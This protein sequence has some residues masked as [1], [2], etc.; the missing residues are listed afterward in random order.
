MNL[1]RASNRISILWRRLQNT[2]A[3]VRSLTLI[4]VY[5]AI[6]VALEEVADYL[7]SPW[8][9]E[10]WNPAAGWHVALIFGFGLRY[11]PVL[12][13]APFLENLQQGNSLVYGTVSGTCTAV[14]YGAASAI[15]LYKLDFDPR[16]TRSRDVVKFAGVFAFA[17]LIFAISEIG[18]L[19]ALGEIESNQ[20]FAKTMHEWAGEAT[21]I[22]MFTPLLLVLWRKF[23]RMDKYLTL[24]AAP[25]EIN[26]SL[27][28]LEDTRNWLGLIFATIL[29]TW[30]ASG[31]IRSQGLDYT[32]FS[33]VPLVFTCAWKGFESTTAIILLIN[34]TTVIFVG[35][36]AVNTNSLALQFG[37]MT[38][39]YTG[40]LLGAFVS[41]RNRES[42]KSKDL[43]EQLRYDA[44]HDSLTGLYNRAWFLNRLD[45]VTDKANNNEDYLFALLFLD[46]DRFKNVNDQLGHIIGDLLLVEIGQKLQECLSESASVARLGG[47]EF[48]ILLEELSNMSQVSQIA[49][50]ICRELNQTYTVDNYEIFISISIGI[51]VNHGDRQESADLVRNADIALYEA[52]ARG[53]SQ[54]IIFDD[55][56]RER[57]IA[58]AQLEQDLRQ[59]IDELL[60]F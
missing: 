14:F 35:K 60:R 21:G 53:K 11:I 43:E 51:A 16:L 24:Q 22:A 8:K 5:V 45:R 46:L 32:Y 25:P 37:L 13:I 58:Q 44:T 39:T 36:N 41:G 28:N 59:A 34:V 49:E 1:D 26:F 7:S 40:L 31:G 57:A 9:V 19:L 30:A 4:T 48:T 29:F 27:P 17:S 38:V 52:K 3:L 20:W 15:L 55:R 47:D 56:M 6:G 18:T 12:F 54:Y 42:N 50:K 23:P 33:F 2:P 10:P